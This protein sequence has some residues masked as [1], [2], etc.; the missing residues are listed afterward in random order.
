LRISVKD[1]YRPASVLPE[2]EK[3]Y[4]EVQS[5]RIVTPLPQDAV[6]GF[7]RGV[8]DHTPSVFDPSVTDAVEVCAQPTTEIASPGHVAPADENQPEPPVDPLKELDPKKAHD[9]TFGSVVNALW[10]VYL[11]GGSQGGRGLEEGRR[12]AAAFCRAHSGVVTVFYRT[13]SAVMT[14]PACSPG[15]FPDFPTRGV[16]KTISETGLSGP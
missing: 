11:E 15:P 7:V 13:V 3:F 8:Q 14:T 10:K 1:F 6:E 2:I 16:Q 12:R 4:R 9:F 5:G